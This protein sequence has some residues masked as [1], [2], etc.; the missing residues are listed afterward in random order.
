[1]HFLEEY[2]E[3]TV[4]YDLIYCFPIKNQ[5]KIP[6]FKS[7]VLNF[8]CK[9]SDV[10]KLAAAALF[11]ELISA[12]SGVTLT[13]SKKANITVKIRK[14]DPVGCKMTLT[15][16]DIYGFLEKF[17]YE[18]IPRVKN[19]NKKIRRS[20]AGVNSISY[21][22]D[23]LLVFK[24]LEDYYSLFTG[25]IPTLDLTIATNTKKKQEMKFLL[26]AFKIPSA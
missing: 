1:M 13:G 18:V 11:M 20:K 25:K 2:Y 15:G 6:R 4:K 21:N 22:F 14:G 10:S 9:S 16:S 8:G 23:D 3:K 12:R 7:I 17:I 24:E 26:R 19:Y 5:K